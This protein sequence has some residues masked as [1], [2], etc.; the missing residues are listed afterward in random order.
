MVDALLFLLSTVIVEHDAERLLLSASAKLRKDRLA[1]HNSKSTKQKSP[2][3]ASLFYLFS[4]LCL[5]GGVAIYILGIKIFVDNGILTASEYQAPAEMQF[6]GSFFSIVSVLAE[7]A[8]IIFAILYRRRNKSKSHRIW[9]IVVLSLLIML[10]GQSAVSYVAIAVIDPLGALGYAV[11]VVV[12]LLVAVGISLFSPSG[13]SDTSTA[14]D[15]SKRISHE[16]SNPSPKSTGRELT[17]FLSNPNFRKTKGDSW[18]TEVEGIF[19]TGAQGQKVYV[20]SV[21]DFESGKAIILNNGK[22][23]T[24]VAGYSAPKQ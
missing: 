22:R 15:T 13:S 17:Y 9:P 16:S 21:Q 5:I 1:M 8:S 24:S 11:S 2:M 3:H 6:K 20:C 7:I 10:I 4:I 23:V 14:S 19:C 18:G 12:I